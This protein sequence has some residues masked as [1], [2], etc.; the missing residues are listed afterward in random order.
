MGCS[1]S[2]P[3]NVDGVLAVTPC[4]YGASPEL[5]HSAAQHFEQMRAR[6]GEVI[7][8]AGDPA[9]QLFVIAS[10][11]VA[12]RVVDDDNKER[13][14]CTR[15]TCQCFGQIALVHA[16]TRT[17]KVVALERTS[18]LTL[19]RAAYEAHSHARWMQ[20][21]RTFLEDTTTHIVMEK[22]NDVPFLRSTPQ[23]KLELLSSL[24]RCVA[25]QAGDVVC[26]QG[27][28]GDSFYII[29]EGHALVSIEDKTGGDDPQVV[30]TMG[31]GSYFGEMA[32]VQNTPRAAT[33]TATEHC[34]LLVLDKAD[35][36]NFLAIA[37][38]VKD[39]MLQMVL[40]RSVANIKE[41]G[42]PFFEYLTPQKV[43]VG[44]QRSKCAQSIQLLTK[45]IVSPLSA[46]ETQHQLSLLAQL[47]TLRLLAPGENVCRRGE[48]GHAFYIVSR[49]EVEVESNDVTAPRVRARIGEWAINRLNRLVGRGEWVSSAVVATDLY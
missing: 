23:A 36:T 44:I 14:V 27:D 28:R 26:R 19:S 47:C 8:N 17:A 10:G 43:S 42:V 35:F 30:H 41:I 15:R 18:F 38:S 20:V 45:L 34:W 16:C 39:E 40:E 37:P 4:F 31:P 32:L 11:S 13:T 3:L 5:I 7:F 33:V 46:L 6:R 25:K 48:E 9:D 22:L 24:F 2:V 49:G 12:V 1:R 21:L 29:L